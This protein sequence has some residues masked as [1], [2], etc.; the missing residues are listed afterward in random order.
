[1]GGFRVLGLGCWA[2]GG[3]RVAVSILRP[4][5]EGWEVETESFM[6]ILQCLDGCIYTDPTDFTCGFRVEL[7]CRVLGL[8][9]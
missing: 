6:Q 3:F 1:M 4:E 2:L 5:L 9:S 7:G 8:W